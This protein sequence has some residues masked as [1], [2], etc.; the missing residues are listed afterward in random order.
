MVEAN[1]DVRP[2]FFHPPIGNTAALALAKSVADLNGGGV[3]QPRDLLLYT[4]S[5][6]NTSTKP[7][8]AV[9]LTDKL[10]AAPAL[11]TVPAAGV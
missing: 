6:T 4:L 10:C 5:L 11:K 1:G 7:I 8:D 9:K 3:V 2:C